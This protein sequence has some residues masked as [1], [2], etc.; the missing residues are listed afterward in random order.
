MGDEPILWALLGNT[1]ANFEDD[2]ELIERITTC[3]GR[4]TC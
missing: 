1:A 4:R 3:C 2:L